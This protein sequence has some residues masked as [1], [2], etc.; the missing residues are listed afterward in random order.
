MGHIR[1]HVVRYD[2]VETGAPEGVLLWIGITIDDH[3]N[4][5]VGVDGRVSELR[6]VSLEGF[7]AAL[8]E[9]EGRLS[10]G[11]NRARPSA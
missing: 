11:D 2:G 9:V 10:T 4:A 6:D 1:P 3:L 7:L 5:R 8:D